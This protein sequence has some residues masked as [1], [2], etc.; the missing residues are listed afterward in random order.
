M[1]GDL[2]EGKLSSNVTV[3]VMVPQLGWLYF[4]VT[5]RTCK[6]IKHSCRLEFSS[7]FRDW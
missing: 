5:S 7:E 6:P 4:L 3:V 1:S 2:K